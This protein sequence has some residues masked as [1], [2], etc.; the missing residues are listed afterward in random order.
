M[1]ASNLTPHANPLDML[2]T[3]EGV[4]ALA[5]KLVADG[6]ACDDS[7]AAIPLGE[8]KA[9]F[10]SVF[11]V[12]SA[13][14]NVMESSSANVHFWQYVSTSKEVRDASMAADKK[15]RD[16]ATDSGMREDVY[17]RVKEAYESM[18]ANKTTFGAEDLRFVEK[19]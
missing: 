16:F 18:K 14:E 5:S 8:G 17:L 9:T 3:P 12:M 4:E 1:V 7:I 13:V 15:M 6:K 2:P 19:V 11:A 10:E